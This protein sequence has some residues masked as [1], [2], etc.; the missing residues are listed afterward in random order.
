MPTNDG[1]PKLYKYGDNVPVTVPNF[2][3]LSLA[4]AKKLALQSSA[5]LKVNLQGSG[6]TVVA[7]SPVGGSKVDDGSTIRLFLGDGPSTRK[8]DKSKQNQ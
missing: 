3:G 8:I 1:I 6:K 5:H 2:Q 7:Q 4:D